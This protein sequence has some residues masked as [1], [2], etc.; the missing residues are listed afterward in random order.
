MLNLSSFL[1]IKF[2]HVSL[3]ESRPCIKTNKGHW[4]PAL[5]DRVALR[6]KGAIQVVISIIVFQCL[7]EIQCISGGKKN[8]AVAVAAVVYCEVT[9]SSS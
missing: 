4:N 5:N 7:C 2:C 3:V 9:S 1:A 6:I 8:I